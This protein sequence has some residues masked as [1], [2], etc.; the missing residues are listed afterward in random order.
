VLEKFGGDNFSEIKE[1]IA[2]WR[3]KTEK[4]LKKI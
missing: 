2:A 1:R 3:K 4:I